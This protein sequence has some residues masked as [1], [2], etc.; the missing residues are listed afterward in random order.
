[1]KSNSN[2]KTFL[3]IYENRL[4]IVSLN[5]ENEIIYKTDSFLDN[6]K[7]EIS[8]DSLNN[9][10]NQNIFK[11]EKKLNEFI[12][13]IYIITDHRDL[14]SIGLSIKEK[15]DEIILSTNSINS[16]LIE[17]KNQ[18]KQT[19]KDFDIIH[20]KIDKFHIDDFSYTNLPE[21]KTCKNFTI[22]LSFICIPS[23]ILKNFEKILS[24]YEISLSKVLSY[25]Y[26]CSFKVDD[27]HN[28]IHEIALKILNGLN[29]NEV[30][31][32]EKKSKNIG[33]FEKFFNF[34]N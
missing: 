29:E 23:I 4:V 6:S 28:D 16:L 17:A 5:S 3:S 33:F 22:D 26:L 18:C 32:T 25:Q 34:F 11:I 1:M 15:K 12:N 10:L 9:F 8:Y 30:F 20:M 27:K 14:F 31:L 21:Q 19:L 2:F 7:P 24:N 13:N